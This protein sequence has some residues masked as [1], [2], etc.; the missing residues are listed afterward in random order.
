MPRDPQKTNQLK[1]EMKFKHRSATGFKLINAPSF[2]LFIVHLIWALRWR[3]RSRKKTESGVWQY[4]MGKTKQMRGESRGVVC[5]S[6]DGRR[7]GWCP[8]RRP[9]TS[10]RACCGGRSGRLR[11]GGAVSWPWEINKKKER[12]KREW[13][14]YEIKKEGCRTLSFIWKKN[15]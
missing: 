15:S 7:C 9:G 5:I 3:Q 12:M 8:C 1:N 11:G 4:S 10:R 14:K 6:R 2:H 13:E